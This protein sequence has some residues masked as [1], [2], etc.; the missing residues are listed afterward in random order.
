MEV[1]SADLLVPVGHKHP[2][3]AFFA[4]PSH[5]RRPG[6]QHANNDNLGWTHSN[7]LTYDSGECES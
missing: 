1:H 4:S 3:E 2:D 5:V 6:M 7:P